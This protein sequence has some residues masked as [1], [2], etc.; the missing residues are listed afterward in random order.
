MSNAVDILQAFLLRDAETL[1][2][3]RT[4]CL[5]RVENRC[6]VDAK[7][8]IR[9]AKTNIVSTKTSPYSTTK[10]YIIT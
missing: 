10:P 8:K 6:R 5:L 7:N 2:T 3:A 1:H 9:K 4:F